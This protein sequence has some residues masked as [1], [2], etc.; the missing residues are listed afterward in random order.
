MRWHIKTI[1]FCSQVCYIVWWRG[2]HKDCSDNSPA[3]AQTGW[4]QREG[5]GRF[6]CQ[7]FV[8]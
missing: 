6:W 5:Q 4:D 7:M 1:T 2:N 8:V 3:C